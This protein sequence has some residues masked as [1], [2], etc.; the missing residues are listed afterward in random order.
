[1][2]DCRVFVDR[3]D[4]CKVGEQN[5]ILYEHD[6][7]SSLLREVG[8][9]RILYITTVSAFVCGVC[10]CVWCMRGAVVWMCRRVC[11]CVWV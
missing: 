8:D 11:G 7:T 6:F 5:S 1:M 10:T 9:E 3:G 4:S 2:L